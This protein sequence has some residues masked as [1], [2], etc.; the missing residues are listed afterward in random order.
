MENTKFTD[1]INRV[2]LKGNFEGSLPETS[3]QY[4]LDIFKV[5]HLKT[6]DIVLMFSKIEQK[7][8]FAHPDST[9]T[10]PPP[11]KN[12]GMKTNCASSSGSSSPISTFY[13]T[14]LLI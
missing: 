5:A 1:I 13:K 4:L 9:P 11:T 12:S 2:K 10:A 7:Y 14:E 8:F 6:D 3:N